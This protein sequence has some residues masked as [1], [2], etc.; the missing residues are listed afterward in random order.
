MDGVID[1]VVMPL[2][3][4]T[5][6]ATMLFLG[7]SSSALSQTPISQG[8]DAARSPDKIPSENAKVTAPRVIYAPDPGYSPEARAAKHQGTCILSMTVGVDGLP[9]DIKIVRGIGMGLDENAVAT[10]ST[11]RYE[12]ARKDGTPVEAQIQAKIFSVCMVLEPTR[13]QNCWTN[14][15]R[16][17]RR[18]TWNLRRPTSRAGM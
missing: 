17:I 12:P 11:W 14:P 1:F 13:Q 3:I 5:L 4:H 6:C 7:V 9:R 18:Q 2:R 16:T 10:A 8:A 15:M